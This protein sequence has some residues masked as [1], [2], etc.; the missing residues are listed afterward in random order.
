MILSYDSKTR[1]P[2]SHHSP[3]QPHYDSYDSENDLDALAKMMHGNMKPSAIPEA[4][5]DP[6]YAHDAPVAKVNFGRSKIASHVQPQHGTRIN[7]TQEAPVLTTVGAS[8]QMALA[9]AAA[10]FIMDL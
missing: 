5:N 1:P 6:Y 2:L 3:I 10:N 7:T 8:D 4:S 9:R